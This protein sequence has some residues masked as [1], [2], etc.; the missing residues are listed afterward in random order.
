VPIVPD[1]ILGLLI[2][3]GLDVVAGL[4]LRWLVATRRIERGVAALL[5]CAIVVSVAA[6]VVALVRQRGVA[7]AFEVEAAEKAT[8]LAV[9][10]TEVMQAVAISVGAALLALVVGMLM[11]IATRRRRQTLPAARSVRG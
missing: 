7:R 9:A 6:A 8:A 10:I 4:L 3:G 5:G 2:A 1:L 11:A